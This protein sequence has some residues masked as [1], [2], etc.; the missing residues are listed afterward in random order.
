MGFY[1][2]SRPPQTRDKP[3][4]NEIKLNAFIKDPKLMIKDDSGG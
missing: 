3:K 1:G 4:A 2:I